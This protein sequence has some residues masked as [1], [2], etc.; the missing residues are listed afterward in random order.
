MRR[1]LFTR[2]TQQYYL[3]RFGNNTRVYAPPPLSIIEMRE[4]ETMALLESQIPKTPEHYPT[5]KTIPGAPRKRR[6][7]RLEDTQSL[8]PVPFDIYKDIVVFGESFQD[9]SFDGQLSLSSVDDIFC[10]PGFNSKNIPKKEDQAAADVSCL[11]K[12]AGSRKNN[13]EEI[14]I[15]HRQ[16]HP[17]KPSPERANPIP[18]LSS[19]NPDHA[20]EFLNE[21][22][23]TEIDE[24]DEAFEVKEV[25]S[26]L[27]CGGCAMGMCFI[28]WEPFENAS[29]K[30]IQK[31]QRMGYR[32]TTSPQKSGYNPTY[33]IYWGPTWESITTISKT[34][35]ETVQQHI[36]TKAP[37]AVSQKPHLEI[38]KKIC[39]CSRFVKNPNNWKLY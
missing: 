10:L 25:K 35:N 12:S 36:T 22:V 34:M 5:V 4:R 30:T 1:F 17:L 6:N 23:G 37:Y 33:V 7:L 2:P 18:I 13:H 8:Q 19:E 38:L 29:R 16:P 9:F 14:E 21:N 15:L 24:T 26:V 39:K 28:E 32:F 20:F 27:M 3:P 31:Y 11:K